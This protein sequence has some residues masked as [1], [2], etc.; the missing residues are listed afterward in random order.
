MPEIITKLSMLL[1]VSFT[2]GINLYLTVCMVGLAGKFGWGNEVGL[3]GFESLANWPVII[4][5]GLLFVVEF[6]AD[7]LPAVDHV[8]NAVHSFVRPVAAAAIGVMVVSDDPAT[9]AAGWIMAGLGAALV[10]TTTNA[11]KVGS[12]VMVAASPEPFSDILL[13]LAGDGVVL[14][15]A[16]LAI[17][18]P[19]PTAIVCTILLAIILYL[20]PLFWRAMA[21]AVRVAWQAA[22]ALFVRDSV[23]HALNDMEP[24]DADALAKIKLA[25]KKAQLVLPANVKGLRGAG[26]LRRGKLIFI[27]GHAVFVYRKWMRRRIVQV[28]V[29]E[30]AHARLKRRIFS[31]LLW[32]Q[33]PRGAMSFL[34]TRR[35]DRRTDHALE[36]LGHAPPP[37]ADG[38][39]ANAS[40]PLPSPQA[41]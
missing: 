12:R 24:E 32:M 17:A 10:A 30:V 3:Q 7:K 38:P 2:S 33:T 27:D 19:V 37:Q 40:P 26:W 21:F 4:I 8:W 28:P 22:V 14:V 11:A 25:H 13:S 35:T 31:N 16:G 39:A 29:A 9:G 18:Y 1:G 20:L 15:L 23:H 6:L 36:L 41:G 5:S 34:T